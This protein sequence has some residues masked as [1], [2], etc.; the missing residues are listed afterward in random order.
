MFAWQF[1]MTGTT[2][3]ILYIIE[4]APLKTSCQKKDR[5]YADFLI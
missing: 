3:A 2:H 5:T 1:S 4:W